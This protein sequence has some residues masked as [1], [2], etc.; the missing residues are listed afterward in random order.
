[1]GDLA[2]ATRIASRLGVAI[3]AA[4]MAIGVIWAILGQFAAGIWWVLIGLFM[5]SAAASAVYQE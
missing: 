1:M 3:A 5:R 4:I 2:A